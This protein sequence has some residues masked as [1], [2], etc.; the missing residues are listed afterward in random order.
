M[1]RPI[2]SK[3]L[4][5]LTT[6]DTLSLTWWCSGNASALGGFNSRVWHGFLCL[7]SFCCCCVFTFCPK[8]HYL[9]P[10]FAIPFAM[11]FFYIILNI[12]HIRFVTDHKDIKIQTLSIFKLVH[13]KLFYK[14]A[15]GTCCLLNILWQ[16]SR[17][18]LNLVYLLKCCFI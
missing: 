1:F 17:E 4:N 2:A 11:L 16:M 6:I 14:F 3:Q 12:L 5:S 13:H 10:N 18:C 8:T 7:I 15:D 9:S